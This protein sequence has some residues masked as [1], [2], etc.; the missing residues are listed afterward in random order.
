MSMRRRHEESFLVNSWIEEALASEDAESDAKVVAK[1]ATRDSYSYDRPL[2]SATLDV[3]VRYP[4]LSD[5]KELCPLLE[6]ETS[7]QFE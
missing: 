2:L 4:I 5:L 3:P 7:A 1:R 6:A